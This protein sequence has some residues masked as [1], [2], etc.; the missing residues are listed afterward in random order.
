MKGRDQSKRKKSILEE[1]EKVHEVHGEEIS[2]KNH[3]Y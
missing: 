3:H 2:F 1:A